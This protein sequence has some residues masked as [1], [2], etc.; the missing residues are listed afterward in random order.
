MLGDTSVIII[1]NLNTISYTISLHNDN[2]KLQ[3]NI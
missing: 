2:I 3:L 1:T